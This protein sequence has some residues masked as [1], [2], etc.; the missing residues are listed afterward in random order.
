M[1]VLVL[2][3]IATGALGALGASAAVVRRGRRRRQPHLRP[4]APPFPGEMPD[5]R[6]EQDALLGEV[7]GPM[8]ERLDDG[9]LWLPDGTSVETLFVPV[10]RV[11][12]DFLG[13]IDVEGNAVAFVGDVSGHGFD[14]GIVALRLKEAMTESIA[15]GASLEDAITLANDLLRDEL[16]SFATV[17]ACRLDGEELSFV[18]AGHLPPLVLE[19]AEGDRLEPTGPLIGA[20]DHRYE[21]ATVPV[22]PSARLLAYTDGLTDAYGA[23]GGLTEAEIREVAAEPGGFVDLATVVDAKRPEPVRD[24]IAA[25]ELVVGDGDDA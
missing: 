7:G 3:L 15:D 2:T 16:A 24:D 18:N 9:G 8:F 4:A 6:E 13:T 17:F 11:G 23:Q 1:V 25:F 14:A 19:G 21:A 10:E 12:G 20:V 5:E 22:D